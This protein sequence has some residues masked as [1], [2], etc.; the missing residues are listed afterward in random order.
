MTIV[1]FPF[2]EDLELAKKAGIEK[3]IN[4]FC[5]KNNITILN[6]GDYIKSLSFNERQ[7]SNMDA[8]ASAK[9]HKI[10]GKKLANLIK[11]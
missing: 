5:N 4:S 7:A 8:H 3:K 6:A 2:M 10:V 9:V 11:F 1:F